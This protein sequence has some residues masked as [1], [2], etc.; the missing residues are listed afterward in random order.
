MTSKGL[1]VRPGWAVSLLRKND[2]K[3][4]TNLYMSENI[5]FQPTLFWGFLLC[6]PNQPKVSLST[7]KPSVIIVLYYTLSC[8]QRLTPVYTPP[9]GW[10]WWFIL[11]G[12][13]Y[14]STKMC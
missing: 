12:M 5:N 4:P 11:G 10:W 7:V 9:L 6:H 2:L 13:D 1:S 8:M 3:H 14:M